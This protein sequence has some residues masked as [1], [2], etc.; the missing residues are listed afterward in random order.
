MARGKDYLARRIVGMLPAHKT[1]VEPFA[2]GLSVLLN[3]PR[4]AQEVVGDLNA[5]LIGFYRSLRNRP[6]ELIDCLRSIPFAHAFTGPRVVS[7]PMGSIC[8]SI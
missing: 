8:G 5:D 3:K 7:V 1:Y 6:R 2:G 4:S